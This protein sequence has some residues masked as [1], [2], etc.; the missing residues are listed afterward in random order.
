LNVANYQTANL[1]IVQ[2]L[3][4][5]GIT[6]SFDTSAQLGEPDGA[7]GQRTENHAA[8]TFPEKSKRPRQ[9]LIARRHHFNTRTA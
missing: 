7:V 3:G 1:Q 5:N 6:D 2:A 9:C 4:E 8:P